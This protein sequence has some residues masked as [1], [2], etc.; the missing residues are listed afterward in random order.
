[1]ETYPTLTLRPGK[2]E[3]LKRY[4]PWIF[5]G[6]LQTVPPG[7][8]EGDTVHVVDA[9]GRPCA[10][11][12]YQP[13][14]IAVRVLAFGAA[15]LDRTFWQ[16]RLHEAIAL[17]RHLGLPS[18]ATDMYRLVHGEGDGL[19]GLIVDYYAGLAVIQCHSM[20]FYRVR[21]K[22]AALLHEAMG[23]TLTAVY[24]KSAG[25]L[26]FKAEAGAVDGYLTGG[27]QAWYGTEHGLRYRVDPAGGQKTGF[28]I[29][30]RDSRALLM[31]YARG[32][33]VLNTFSY[34]GGFSV[35]ALQG[36]AVLVDSVD[37]SRGAV[38]LAVENVQLNFGEGAPHQGLAVD[39]F[40]FF[41]QTHERPYD[42]IVLD[43]PAFAKHHKVLDRALKGYRR[44]N[45]Q[46]FA[47]VAP[48]GIV[49][50]FSCSQAVSRD[51][52]RRAVFTAAALSGRRV[53][54]LHQLSQPPDH[55]VDIYH[56]EGEYLKGLV[57]A[58]E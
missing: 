9:T 8:A 21:H 50:T 35:A 10:T 40:D 6:A 24:D 38:A 4:H 30:Q 53:R 23:D 45:Q 17:R 11:G 39:V 5:S 15:Q 52:F 29:D 49:F 1:M 22:I 51:D 3:S 54:I 44:L 7:L 27:P 14:S 16:T 13:G 25:S 43:P 18:A 33:R 37:S 28:F 55:P 32:R 12:H 2:E 31:Q 58:V 47:Q 34:T 20:G 41:Q 46:A 57:L 48:G 56:P 42:L 26:P 19:S 36:G